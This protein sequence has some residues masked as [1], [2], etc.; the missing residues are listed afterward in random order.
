M[1]SAMQKDYIREI[2]SSRNRFLS[3]MVLAGLAVAFLSGL[4]ATAPDMKRTG[5]DYL[6]AQH[7]Q[8]IQ[9][10]SP[11][12]ITEEDV[13]AV[14]SDGH[15]AYAEGAY[16]IDAWADDVVAKVYSVTEGVN[17]LVLREGR[18]PES[19]NECVADRALLKEL[20]LSL[21]DTVSLTPGGSYEGALKDERYTVV[22]VV[23]SPYYVS[24]ERGSASIGSGMV[25]AYVYLPEEAFDMECYTVCYALAEGAEKMI[26]FYDEY[27]DYISDVMEALE[28]LG[29]RR[30]QIRHGE[31]IDEAEEKL[32]DAEREFAEAKAEAEKEF[33]KAEAELRGARKKLDD[34]WAGYNSG[35]AELRE[36]EAPL[37]AAEQEMQSGYEKLTAGEEE[38]AAGKQKYDDGYAAY[39][40]G[41]QE[42]D[43]GYEKL[44]AGQKEFDESCAQMGLS[45]NFTAAQADRRIRTLISEIDAGI[46][47]ADANIAAKRT[48]VLSCENTISECEAAMQRYPEGSLLYRSAKE[49]RD[50]AAA[51]RDEALKSIEESQ[52]Q[53]QALQAQKQLL[54]QTSGAELVQA[55]NELAAGWADYEAGLREMNAGKAELDAA[56][57][58]LDAARREL[59]SG[60][61]DYH[62]GRE[63][64]EAGKKKAEEGRAELANAYEELTAGEREYREGR[65]EYLRAR[66]EADAELADGEKELKDARRKVAEIE[67][68]EW[69]IL[70]R[71]YDPGYTGFGDDADRM[72]NLASVFPVIFFLVAALVCLTTMTRMVEEQRT[73]IGLMKAIGYSRWPISR[74]YLSYGLLP[75]LVGSV[76]G[77]AIGHLLFPSM[78]YIAYQ[79]MYETPNIRLRFYP[80]ISAWATLAA[81]ACTTV[82]TLWACIATLADSPANLMRPR[83]P[84][85]GRRVLL[86]RIGFIWKRLNFNWKVTVRNL[87]RYQKRF[88][89]TVIG[90]GGCTALMIAGFGIRDSLLVTM[91]RQYGEL[92]RYDAQI[93]MAGGILESERE[94]LFSYLDSSPSVESYTE[95]YATSLTA[96]TDAYSTGAFLEVIDRDAIGGFVEVHDAYTKAPMPLSDSGVVIDQKLSELLDVSVGDEIVLSGEG[97]HTAT[98]EG[99]YENYVAHFIYLTPA[100]YEKIFGEAV[101]K[102]GLLLTTE[103]ESCESVITELLELSGVS[104]A[105]RAS[106]VRDTYTRSMQRIDF[107][108]VIIIICA[109]ALAV[110]VLYNLSNI[111][112]TERAREMATL[113]VLGFHDLEVTAYVCRENVILTLVGIAL[114][115]LFG[116][117]LH[118]WLILSVEIDLMMFGR[119]TG[120]FSYLWSALLTV[121]FSAAVNVI[122]HK[123]MQKIDM[124]ESLKSAE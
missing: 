69:Y 30:A 18:M 20:G 75:S 5:D 40:A 98:V 120:F 81:V 97:R 90:I 79:I 8:D 64:Y 51:R 101:E 21:G 95:I 22:G 23:R 44:S 72:A 80:D 59:D 111:N 70:S 61:K 62:A 99:I 110:T 4:K 28:P 25:R 34:G 94:E 3:I 78:I 11:L 121:L 52:A 38:Y 45:E 35:M 9:I 100:A 1:R 87:L 10:L 65:A 91:E 86:E 29:E 96:E 76:L 41:K 53:K 46:L 68:G 48:V 33:A 106:D 88:W 77:L 49:R 39:L 104:A 114:G 115:C 82:S 54:Q 84:K 16:V 102:N 43:A 108:V 123:K 89:M 119:S 92:F 71:S 109:A 67:Q 13:R 66:A 32:A 15:I 36:A 85:A 93:T 37:A 107:V 24:V 57:E 42:L 31:I 117:Y 116:K 7:L 60:W 26:A 74:K 55:R 124:V 83:A 73:Q 50:E 118:A 14:A 56:K 47:L 19:A 27:N 112:I 6:D 113:K 63:K 58:E 2:K 17:K 105:S 103:D 122:A 12:G